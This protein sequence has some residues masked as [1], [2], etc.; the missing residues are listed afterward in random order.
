LANLTNLSTKFP[1]SKVP[2]YIFAQTFGSFLACLILSQYH[3]QLTLLAANFRSKGLTPVSPGG[4]GSVLPSFLAA[5]ET[6]YGYLFFIE[7]VF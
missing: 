5:T 1:W 4:P 2:R 7:F 3:P 6:K